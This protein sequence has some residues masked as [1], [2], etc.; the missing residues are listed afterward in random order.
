MGSRIVVAA[1]SSVRLGSILWLASNLGRQRI[2][3]RC[4][5]IAG[6]LETPFERIHARRCSTTS[7]SGFWL[8]GGFSDAK[9]I[10]VAA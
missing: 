1:L 4:G 10:G 6:V 7:I 5:Q 9:P 3:V 8:D 2:P